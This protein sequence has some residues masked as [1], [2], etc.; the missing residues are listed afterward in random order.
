[1]FL[2]AK[3]FSISFTISKSAVNRGCKNNPDPNWTSQIDLWGLIARPYCHDTDIFSSPQSCN[4]FNGEAVKKACYL[5][6]G[7]G[8]GRVFWCRW[9]LFLK[10]ALH[11]QKNGPSILITV[12]NPNW[13]LDHP[14]IH[15]SIHQTC[16]LTLVFNRKCLEF[17][18]S[19]QLQMFFIE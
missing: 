13:L 17:N 16:S 11:S 12:G 5:V 14:S 10:T 1:M 18:S 7:V 19:N 4:G 15:P 6:G 3:S 2:K 8:V 9:N